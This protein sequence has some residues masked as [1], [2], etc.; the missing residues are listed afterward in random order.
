MLN[1]KVKIAG[2]KLSVPVSIC[3]GVKKI[4]KQKR[5]GANLLVKNLLTK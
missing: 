5:K 2:A 4:T 3:V 1:K